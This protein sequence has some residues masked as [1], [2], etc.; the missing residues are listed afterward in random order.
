[1]LGIRHATVVRNFLA[2][3]PETMS[4]TITKFM[5]KMNCIMKKIVYLV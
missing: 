2:E 4:E 5:K 3:V 1:M